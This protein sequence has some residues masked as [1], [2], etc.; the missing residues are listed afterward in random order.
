MRLNPEARYS[1]R[2][3]L[4]L[5]AVLLQAGAASAQNSAGMQLTLPQAIDLALKQN[6]VVKLAQLDVVQNEQKK[7]I[8]Q[9]DYFP[10]LK[11]ESTVIHLTELEQLVIPAGSLEVPG[12]VGPVPSKTAV[13]GQ[14]EFTAYTSGTGLSQPLTQMFKVHQVNL[15]ATADIH[16]A[17]EAKSG[18][19][20]CRFEDQSTVLR[21]SDRAAKGRGGESG[22]GSSTSETARKYEFRRTRKR[23][24][25]GSVGESRS[26][27][28]R[29]TND[30]EAKPSGPRFDF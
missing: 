21:N 17:R 5:A 6:R 7:K 15:A 19:E 24:G 26:Y 13:I 18:R 27:P 25:S 1:A 11:N 28:R 30:P 8:A 3:T 12:I 2:F 14:G 23:A 9:A 20:R 22:G 4:I 16:S 29:K 10:R